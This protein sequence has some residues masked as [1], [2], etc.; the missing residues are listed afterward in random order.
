VSNE[1]LIAPDTTIE[2]REKLRQK[3]E[4]EIGFVLD[5]TWLPTLMNYA[6]N[7]WDHEDPQILIDCFQKYRTIIPEKIFD[8]LTDKTIV[9]VLKLRLEE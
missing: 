8:S 3:T 5:R 4:E 2:E 6:R 1:S 9:P 7:R